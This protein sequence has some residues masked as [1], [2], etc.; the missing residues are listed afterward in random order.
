VKEVRESSPTEVASSCGFL[1]EKTCATL[2]PVW[3]R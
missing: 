2:F 3:E 1:A